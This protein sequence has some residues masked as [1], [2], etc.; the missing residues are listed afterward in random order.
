MLTMI[1]SSFAMALLW[2]GNSAIFNHYYRTL[3][4]LRTVAYFSYSMV[5]GP[6]LL[7]MV[8]F[9]GYDLLYLGMTRLLKVEAL[10]DPDQVIDFLKEDNKF[11]VCVAKFFR[12]GFL[13]AKIIIF[14]I[15][16]GFSYLLISNGRDLLFENKGKMFIDGVPV[17]AKTARVSI[18]EDE[19][20]A[21]IHDIQDKSGAEI[22]SISPVIIHRPGFRTKLKVQLADK[23]LEKKFLL[24]RH[25]FIYNKNY[26]EYMPTRTESLEKVC[27]GEW[28][29][30]S[31]DFVT[32][33]L[34][35]VSING[36]N[37]LF[38]QPVDLKESILIAFLT[39]VQQGEIDETP[40]F[41]AG[42][43]KLSEISEVFYHRETNQISL[44][45]TNNITGGSKFSFLLAGPDT[46]AFLN[47]GYSSN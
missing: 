14:L 43:P 10:T 19:L 26:E 34:R 27:H 30:Y 46:F 6:I 47:M 45:T 3:D 8:I 32:D 36:E 18:S 28:F 4:C 16:V 40:F 23:I 38:S 12:I 15:F 37:L 42:Y 31:D 17:D 44:I 21:F 35:M 5:V 29:F 9:L 22:T 13:V 11:F 7:L 2:P 1:C 39:K 41:F 33:K 25:L 24:R 20:R